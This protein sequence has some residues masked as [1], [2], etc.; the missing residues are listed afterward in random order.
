MS[1]FAVEIAGYPGPL[2]S[3]NQHICNHMGREAAASPDINGGILYRDFILHSENF[4][5]NEV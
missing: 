1:H 3:G 2:L 5:L 4:A